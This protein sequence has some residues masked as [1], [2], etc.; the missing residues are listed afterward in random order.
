MI[1]KRKANNWLINYITIRTA[2]SILKKPQDKVKRMLSAALGTELATKFVKKPTMARRL[3]LL[4]P[5]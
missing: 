4:K 5:G 1:Y 2:S 3:G